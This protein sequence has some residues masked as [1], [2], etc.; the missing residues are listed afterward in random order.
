MSADGSA[1]PDRSSSRGLRNFFQDSDPNVCITPNIGQNQI[2]NYTSCTLSFSTRVWRVVLTRWLCWLKSI[3]NSEFFL[4]R[5]LLL[6]TYMFVFCRSRPS[7][8]IWA[9]WNYQPPE[10]Y[11]N[12]VSWIIPCDVYN[13]FRTSKWSRMHQNVCLVRL[14]SIICESTACVTE[15]IASPLLLFS[16]ILF[17]PLELIFISDNFI[18]PNTAKYSRKFSLVN[19]LSH[20]AMVKD[21]DYCAFAW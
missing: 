4:V 2:K 16:R 18:S 14:F 9:Q 1:S 13:C 7:W 17:P 11:N 15:D 21:W 6:L 12:A 19:R 10:F 8:L 5:L 3:P 20:I